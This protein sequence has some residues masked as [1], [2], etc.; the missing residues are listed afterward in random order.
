MRTVLSMLSVA[1]AA[2]LNTVLAIMSIL[3]YFKKVTQSPPVE[4]RGADLHLEE[5]VQTMSGK[6]FLLH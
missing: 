1:I 6:T 3:N 2:I 4:D 5:P